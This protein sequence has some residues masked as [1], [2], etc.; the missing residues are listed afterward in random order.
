MEA[1]G[2]AVGGV[3]LARLFS[4]C[5]VDRVQS[6]NSFGTDSQVLETQFRTEK[7]RFQQWGGYVGF[8]QETHRRTIIPPSATRRLIRRYAICCKSSKLSATQTRLLPG[9]RLVSAPGLPMTDHWAWFRRRRSP[10]HRPHRG[11]VGLL[12]PFSVSVTSFLETVKQAV[13][14]TN[15]RIM[16]VGRDESEIRHTLTDVTNGAFVEYRI[17]SGDVRADTASYSTSIVDRKL[18]NKSQ[19]IR[20]DI[21]E[22][23][24]GRCEGQFLWLKMQGDSLSG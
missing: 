24:T 2:V 23:M 13:T 15:T 10:V 3:G 19:E 22:R 12:G 20:T 8:D 16:V 9:A 21:S 5:L 1:A 14:G 6:Y 4:S 7:L 18:F 17:S 11:E